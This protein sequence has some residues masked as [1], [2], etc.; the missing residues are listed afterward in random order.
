MLRIAAGLE[1]R[2]HHA[3]IACPV[4]SPLSAR[5]HALQIA[6][7]PLNAPAT[8]DE[9][10]VYDLAPDDAVL[11][12]QGGSRFRR[13]RTIRN[14]ARTLPAAL[15][16]ARIVRANAFSLVLSNSPRAATIGGLAARLTG[17]PSVTHVRDIVHSPFGRTVARRVLAFAS[18]AFVAASVATRDIITL[19]RVV[20]VIH[21]G[22]TPEMLRL[23]P[24]VL[25]QQRKEPRVG[26]VAH[27]S[28]WKG[29]ADFIRAAALVLE[30][31]PAARFV[32]FGGDSGQAPLVAYRRVLEQM[33]RELGI[34]DRVRLAGASAD[35]LEEIAQLDVFVHPPTAPD[36]FPGAVLE[37]AALCRP[38]VATRT[39]GI[40]EIIADGRS[41]LLVPAREPR[42]LADAIIELLD[43]RERAASCGREARHAA[44]RFTMAATLDGVEALYAQLL[45][46]SRWPGAGARH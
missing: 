2:G 44:E 4:P 17:R 26:M 46:G 23:T 15:S 43:N 9:D 28:P 40:P 35:V 8:F 37:A 19:D 5:A 21:D 31:Y 27:L 25:R 41:G 42:Q 38:I 6:T 13:V 14:Y 30:R 18:D 20:R 36:P 32:C 39:G 12:W 34:H 10:A 22:L 1:A 45:A 29:H 11:S 24:P 33:I 7:F 3:A 16:V